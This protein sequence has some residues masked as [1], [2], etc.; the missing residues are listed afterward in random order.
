L[1]SPS[2]HSEAFQAACCCGGHN[3]KLGRMGFG[4]CCANTWREGARTPEFNNS[5]RRPGQM[6]PARA[7]CMDKA[8][9]YRA[10]AAK[11]RLEAESARLDNL[12]AASL[13]AAEKWECLAEE[14][15]RTLR[16]IAQP[17]HDWFS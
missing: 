14:R 2:T 16:L 4:P 6:S 12:R 13:R 9:E 8:A 15:E 5:C 7:A 10:L 3:P 11:F 17:R 1:P